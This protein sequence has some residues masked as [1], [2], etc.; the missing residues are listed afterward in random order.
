MCACVLCD[1]TVVCLL[2]TPNFI[3]TQMTH[4]PHS[5]TF[6]PRE[7]AQLNVASHRSLAHTHTAQHIAHVDRAIV[8]NR[9]KGYNVF[10]QPLLHSASHRRNPFQW[11]TLLQTASCLVLVVWD[12]LSFMV[13]QY[14][15]SRPP[16]S[17]LDSTTSTTTSM[18]A[19]L[20]EK[21]YEY[22]LLKFPAAST[23]KHF[24]FHSF[25][26]VCHSSFPFSMRQLLFL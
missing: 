24:F 26:V 15:R 22:I 16:C 2:S 19:R 10:L 6:N 18:I 12:P 13:R 25:D 21:K 7:K 14:S 4:T 3:Q 23:E 1:V 17:V 5:S 20:N 11:G 8:T 9:Q